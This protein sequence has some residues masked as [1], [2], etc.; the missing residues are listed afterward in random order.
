VF[1]GPIYCQDGTVLVLAG[2][3]MTYDQVNRIRCLV[4]GVVGTLP[5]S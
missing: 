5:R 3:T 4:K 2:Q 1:A